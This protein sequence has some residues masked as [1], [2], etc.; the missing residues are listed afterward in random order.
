MDRYY[1][2]RLGAIPE[3]EKNRPP[4]SKEEKGKGPEKTNEKNQ[5]P[6]SWGDEKKGVPRD[7]FF[8]FTPKMLSIKMN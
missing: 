7:A 8:T 6:V 1:G 3:S 2:P 4:Q 5:S